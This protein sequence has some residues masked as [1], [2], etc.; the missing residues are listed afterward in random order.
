M[1]ILTDILVDGPVGEVIKR[2]AARK[3]SREE[4]LQKYAQKKAELE[5]QL[6]TKAQY[7]T[8]QKSIADKAMEAA[9][10]KA[11]RIE[12]EKRLGIYKEPEAKA[13]KAT[14]EEEGV[15]AAQKKASQIEEEKRLG[16][17]KETETK[18]Q[19]ESYSARKIRELQ[20]ELSGVS[21]IY[22]ED[23][24]LV[25]ELNVELPYIGKIMDYPSS[26]EYAETVLDIQTPK[27]VPVTQRMFGA[28][29]LWP[30]KNVSYYYDAGVGDI[31]VSEDGKV[32]KLSDSPYRN[33]I[34]SDPG[35]KEFQQKLIEFSTNKKKA[36]ILK[37]EY[38]KNKALIEATRRK[39]IELENQLK[40]YQNPD[41]TSYEIETT[42]FQERLKKLYS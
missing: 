33:E 24:K 27:S 20:A 23:S 42:S 14:P 9:T 28:D 22:E 40:S 7:T 30:D 31:V 37:K 41:L 39:K 15:S 2:E 5:L 11:L 21:A 26:K 32:K 4:I 10:E 6:G 25:D 1:S 35:F 19:S 12:A 17:Y 36:E 29:Y 34:I 38:D 8:P 13:P 18:P 16:I 3:R